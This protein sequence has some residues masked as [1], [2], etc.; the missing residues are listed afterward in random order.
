MG[1]HE[2]WW[3]RWRERLEADSDV[4]A[5]VGNPPENRRQAFVKLTWIGIWLAYMS[6]PVSDLL[7]DEMS[8]TATVLGWTGLIG[9]VA[10]YLVLVFRHTSWALSPPLVLS[11]LCALVA[12]AVILPLA[13]GAPWLVL[14]VYLSITCGAVLPNQ[15]SRWVVPATTALLILV[16]L[17]VES[18]GEL[19]SALVIP[20]LLGGY[21]ML[22]IRQMVRT[23]RALREARATVAHLAANEERL[24]LARD[25]HDLLGHSLS[26]IALKSELAGRMLPDHPEQAATQVA[27][28]ER[29]GRQALV[30]VREAVSGFRRP[31]LA[32]E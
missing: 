23:T 8:L 25:L 17:R 4:S 29:V 1:V 11:A 14:W 5:S 12:L 9:F 32:G 16:G 24:R 18:A 3:Q 2:R 19:L 7:S 13:F 28:I 21:A 27:D 15:L 22:G 20:C 30:D 6:A 26:L 10:V 31:T